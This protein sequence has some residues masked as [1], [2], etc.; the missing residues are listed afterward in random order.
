MGRGDQVSL[1]LFGYPEIIRDPAGA[2]F[3]VRG[4][5][6]LALL[7]LTPGNKIT[8]QEAAALIWDSEDDK[9]SLTSLRQLIARMR[10]T[11]PDIDD[12][13]AVDNRFL[14]LGKSR[15]S[16]DVCCFTDS[17]H[18]RSAE[19]AEALLLLFRGE[20]LSG[21]FSQS[22][23]FARW[24]TVER[25][26]LAEKFFT[27]SASALMAITQYGR[28]DA[29]LVGRIGERMLAFD[30][31]REE[32]YSALIGAYRRLGDAGAANRTHL[33]LQTMLWR[34]FDIAPSVETKSL[35]RRTLAGSRE[36]APG[37]EPQSPNPGN[38]L[39]R[40]AFLA[41]SWLAPDAQGQRLLAA[42]I[43]DVANEL[44]RYRSFAVL[45]A[46]SSF[47]ASH[48]GGIISDNGALRADHTVSGFVKPG[49]GFG[50]LSLRMV[51]NA[52]GVIIWSGEFPLEL[53]L[54]ANS[55]RNLVIRVA[56]NLHSELERHYQSEL[57]RTNSNHAYLHFLNGQ[58]ALK[59]SDLKSLRRARSEFKAAVAEDAR[60]SSAHAAVSNTLYLEWV[61]LGG[62]DPQ[63]LVSAGKCADTAI[64]IDPNTS[65]GHW[66]KAMVELYQHEFDASERSFQDA[67]LLSPNSPDILLDYGDA[68]GH[69]GDANQAWRLF[70]KAIDLNPMPPDYYWW[71]GAGISFSKND[72]AGSVELC[73]RLANDEP[74]LRLLAA[75]HGMLGNRDQA[76]EYGRQLAETYPGE[77]AHDMAKLQPHR[78]EASLQTFI[79]GLR[80][81]GVR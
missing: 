75:S 66:R 41:P 18:P 14:R 1:R 5:Q 16:I 63:L 7:A 60:F 19:E 71:V 35:L 34:E 74:V 20:L 78:T 62:S 61:L 42:L 73:G 44:S 28:A 72:F 50:I 10:K 43:E 8:R 11:S 33:A 24:L 77:T 22:D 48:D 64:S 45:A 55:F 58:Q 12:F 52:T 69:I 6:L 54:L 2:V 68:L 26:A 23:A 32:T 70:E 79:E 38:H 39:P 51:N 17:P 80:M 29:A 49:P 25:A 21:E 65:S 56:A 3:P 36:T 27:A 67:Q 9:A 37:Q 47:Q 31:E 59:S 57:A 46:H 76:R 40:V 30:P 53:S 4:F 13:L 81:A 15:Q